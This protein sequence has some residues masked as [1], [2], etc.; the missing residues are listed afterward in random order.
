[1]TSDLGYAIWNHKVG[2]FRVIEGVIADIGD[3]IWNHKVGNAPLKKTDSRAMSM[4]KERTAP[5][6][7]SA[8]PV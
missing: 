1:M 5:S 4:P 6:S 2:E 8:T 3:A 7:V